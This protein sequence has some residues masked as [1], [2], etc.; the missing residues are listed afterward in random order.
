MNVWGR[1]EMCARKRKGERG[2]LCVWERKEE[3]MCEG[4]EMCVGEREREREREREV[5]VSGRYRGRWVCEGER[6]KRCVCVKERLREDVWVW[7]KGEDA[8]GGIT[9]RQKKCRNTFL[10]LH[11]LD[12]SETP[13][14]R[15]CTRESRESMLSILDDDLF[16]KF[17]EEKLE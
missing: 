15:A 4:E 7:V 2:W 5:N 1:E 9:N 6:E 11:H 13:E 8:Q 3:W 14:K 10:W 17:I 12:Y 16:G